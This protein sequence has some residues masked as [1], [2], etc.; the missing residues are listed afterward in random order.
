MN[1]DSRSGSWSLWD[2]V[3][4]DFGVLNA[5]SSSPIGCLCLSSSSLDSGEAMAAKLVVGTAPNVKGWKGEDIRLL[6]DIQ[7]EPR[8]VLWVKQSISNQ[9]IPKARYFDGN[10]NSLEERFNIDK[11]FSLD[12][13]DLEVADNGFYLCQVELI[14]H[15]NFENSTLLTVNSMA[16]EHVIEECVDKSPSNQSICT[17]QNPSATLSINLTCVVSGFKP[18]IS[19]LWTDESG[20]RRDSVVSQQTTLSDDTYKRVEI[21]TVSAI[22]GIEQT[23][24]CTATG[25]SLNGTSTV[26]I[27][28]LPISGTRENV[29]LVIGLAICLSTA[30]IILVA[31]LLLQK[32]RAHYLRNMSCCITCRRQRERHQCDVQGL[33]M[34][35]SCGS[36]LTEE[37]V[38]QFK[39]ELKAYYRKTY[40]KVNVNPVNFMQCVD[41]DD[42]YTNVCIACLI[43]QDGMQKRSTTFER[44]L[45]DHASGYLS[46]RLLIQGEGGVGKTTLCAKIAWDWSQGEILRDLDLLIVIPLQSV[47]ADKT[48]GSVLDRYL[49][50]SNTATPAQI[51][52]YISTNLESVLI[53]LDGFDEFNEKIEENSRSEFIRILALQQYESCKL[54]VTTRP[55][56]KHDFTL[57]RTLSEDYTFIS[58][59]GFKKENF[60]AYI[61]RYFRIRRE[62]AHAET[63]LSFLEENDFIRDNMAPFPIYCAMLCLMWKEFT[64]ERR[65]ALQ[66][67]KT[68]SEIFREMFS[69]LKDHYASKFCRNVQVDLSKEHVKEADRAIKNISEIAFCGLLDRESS[70][71]EERFEQ[72]KDSMETCCKVG[73]LTIQKHFMERKRRRDANISSFVDSTVSFPHRL[74][75]EYIAGIYICILF[76][77]DRTEYNNTKNKLLSRHKEF[78][79]VL[80]FTSSL[81]NELGMDIINS[82]IT[83]A[84]QY[85]CVDVAFE[86]HKEEACRAVG[87]Q[88]TEYKLLRNTSEHT[89]S[90]IA[91]I[92]QCDQV[93]TLLIDD[94]DCG[95]TVSRDLADGMCSSNVLRK[96]TINASQLLNIDFYKTI[97]AGASDCQI[98]ELKLSFESLDQSSVGANLVQWVCTMPNLFTFS[99]KCDYLADTFISTAADLTSSCQIQILRFSRPY[100]AG[101]S[102]N[103][104]TVGRDLARLVCTMPRLSDFTLEDFRLADGFFSTAVDLAASCQIRCLS[105]EIKVGNSEQSAA[106]ETNLVE[107]LRLMSKLERINL[108][109]RNVPRTLFTEIARQVTHC[110][111]NDIIINNKALKTRS[112]ARSVLSKEVQFCQTDFERADMGI[113]P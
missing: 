104:S 7:E 40:R 12:I 102:N 105:L 18:N 78:R 57:T 26:G 34:E 28:L 20:K 19:M 4:R 77:N 23:F 8:H 56:R 76:A 113:R 10:F 74:F 33:I 94:V 93:K 39:R 3:R 80:Y 88:W 97:S 108:T 38:H 37:Q 72:C 101:A 13:T 59:D 96:V 51:D 25:D 70:F 17:Y 84:D 63:L 41:L 67:M 24:L 68:F 106:A 32:Y 42:I 81:E 35:S 60:S 91:F 82:L 49:S 6:C 89:K 5:Y 98:S 111:R 71:L 109:W 92:G 73:V 54:I 52:N 29:G 64:D 55:W 48:I 45:A 79:Y 46:K 15:Q 11:N 103:Q 95:K 112:R 69:F 27:T 61:K 86:C 65:R 85:F 9:Q 43:D 87:K 16:T 53:V 50:D 22:H 66:K 107:F 1:G 21:A 36:S 75:Q 44:L 62:D 47:T 100:I 110:K 2:D 90:G 30:V 99:L 58:L 83:C 31:G 14:G